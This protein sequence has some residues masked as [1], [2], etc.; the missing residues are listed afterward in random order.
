VL[1]IDDEDVSRYLV[2]QCLPAPVFQVLEASGGAE[3]I[4]CAREAQPEAILLDL[5]MP[6]MDGRQVL[7]EL[8][9]DATTR[10]IPVLILTSS[11]PDSSQR[12]ELLTHAADVLSKATMS[13]K[14]LSDAVQAAVAGRLA[15]RTSI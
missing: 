7:A 4:A 12:A 8:S 13:R 2:K 3:G 14:T 9:A 11:E 5:V 10:D 6:G 1:T 15:R